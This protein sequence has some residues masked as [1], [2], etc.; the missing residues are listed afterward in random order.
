MPSRITGGVDTH[1]DVHVAAALDEPGF[2][3]TS[4]FEV[5]QNY[6]CV[7][8]NV[9]PTGIVS[10]G[11]DLRGWTTEHHREEL[12]SRPLRHRHTAPADRTSVT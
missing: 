8:R 2:G 6:Y 12:G 3:T 5:K 7:H 1:L 10:V 4:D 11:P 9:N